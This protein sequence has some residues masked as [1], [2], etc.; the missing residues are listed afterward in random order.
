[1][2][3]DLERLGRIVPTVISLSIGI[4]VLFSF[5]FEIEMLDLLQSVFVEWTVIVIAFSM[6]LGVLNVLRVHA[7]RIQSR[8]G[9][10]YSLILVLSFLAV[11]IPGIVTPNSLSQDLGS[12]VGPQ[13]SIVDFAYRY[14][15][16]PLQAT[17]FSLMAFFVATAAW[18]AFR[19]RNAA[20][21][22]MFIS[23]VLVLLGSI[24]I[25]LGNGWGL[26]TETKDWILSVPAMAG[27]RGILLGL[28]LG[29]IVTGL[30][31]LLGVDR[32]YND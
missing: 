32:P 27:A 7:K 17:L 20:S 21:F 5:L 15:Q 31:L 25:T 18:R 13:G 19:I 12:F 14:V 10:V 3:I 22:V 8:Q 9:A 2:K 4:I 16:R 11:F 23:G 28:A 29:T 24:K 1:L 6:L 26:V 30:R